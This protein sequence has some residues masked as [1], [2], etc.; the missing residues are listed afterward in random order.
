M[1]FTP[2]QVAELIN[3]IQ[4]QHILFG[5]EN[6]GS[7]VLSTSEVAL[8][9]SY[10]VRVSELNL[11]MSPVEEAFHFGRLSAA[12]GN[13]NT[14]KVSYDDFR[15]FVMGGG[16]RELSFVERAALENL[17][18]N[19]FNA[20]KGLGN[21]VSS[22]ATEIVGKSKSM[23]SIQYKRVLNE[24]LALGV[25]YRKSVGEIA[26]EIGKR[27]GDWNRDLGRL[28][29]TELHNAYEEGRALE[30]EFQAGEDVNVYK[31]VYAG[32]CK[33]CIAAYLTAGIGSVP[34]IFKLSELR[35]N[36]D[37]VGLKVSEWRP[38][39]GGMHPF[40]R[41]TLHRLLPGFRWDDDKKAFVREA[42]TNSGFKYGIKVTIGSN[43]F[44]I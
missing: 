15:K 20:V 9:E 18:T 44:N 31:D 32:A 12:L 40:C 3:I 34:K 19:T 4:Y 37:N 11:A 35:D 21:K 14:A 6:V 41:C 17:K 7:S 13:Y 42:N 23:R 38:V 30:F 33:Y 27:T 39:L 10:G 29:E 1:I 36:G 24:E 25:E 16:H 26:R 28:V 43:V 22:N 5:V 2:D 8:L